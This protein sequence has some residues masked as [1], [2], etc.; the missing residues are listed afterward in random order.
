MV[1][2][3]SFPFGARPIFRG[4]LLVSGRVNPGGD[5]RIAPWVKNTNCH[6]FH[7]VPKQTKINPRLFSR[8]V[9]RSAWNGLP[10]SLCT[11]TWQVKESVI[12]QVVQNHWMG[13][14]D[15]NLYIYIYR[16]DIGNVVLVVLFVIKDEVYFP[17][18]PKNSET[19]RSY[20]M[21]KSERY[22]VDFWKSGGG[23][24]W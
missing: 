2:I 11:A 24:G 3:R 23:W 22:Q 5:W 18:M 6:F 9:M 13:L 4:E 21:M 8:H 14:F 16:H 1:G 7:L 20:E 12:Q 17:I 15:C 10:K 19:M